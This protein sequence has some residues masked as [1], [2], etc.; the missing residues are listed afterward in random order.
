MSNLLKE[1]FERLLQLVDLKTKRALF[2]SFQ[3][4][5]LTGLIGPRGVGKTTLML[6]YIK[7][8]DHQEGKIFYF[9]A[10]SVYFRQTTLLEFVDELYKFE[11]YRTF[12]IDEI[13]QYKNWS[14]ELKNIYDSYPNIKVIF[15][16]SSMLE[17]LEGSH[18]LSRRVNTYHLPG[19]SFREYLSFAQKLNIPPVS[20]KE[21]LGNAK[22]Y[23]N[24]GHI[25][26]VLGHFRTYLEKGY[27]P[28]FFEDPATYSERIMQVVGKIIFEDIPNCFDLKTANLHLFKQLLGYLASITPGEANTNNIARNIG[29]AH[30]T[31]E[32]YLHILDRV[33]LITLVYPFEGG[34]QYLRKPQ[35]IFIHNTNLLHTL[36]SLIGSEIN[37]GNVRELFFLQ[38]LRDAGEQV[39]YSK[40]DY[41]AGN[42]IFE[43]GGKNKTGAQLQGSELPGILVKD[44]ILYPSQNTIPL[45][46]FGFINS[47]P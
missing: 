25:D 29:I 6:Q 35:K 30:Q 13:H 4:K 12:F 24:L 40:Q 45:F 31:V 8:H 36:N 23:S 14:Q 7:E 33:G 47:T 20:F 19:L 9:S 11:G 38:A 26:T 42:H 37:Q 21:L 32:H 2:D 22:D 10:D 28:F 44:D 5:R 34:G 3:P 46:Y 41:R 16:G 15:S 27:Y 43:I 17:L 18:D 39:F 1:T